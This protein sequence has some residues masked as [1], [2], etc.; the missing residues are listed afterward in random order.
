MTE[1]NKE[2]KIHEIQDKLMTAIQER[3][4]FTIRKLHK[5]LEKLKREKK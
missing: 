1:K 3:Q 5:E 4:I 2:K